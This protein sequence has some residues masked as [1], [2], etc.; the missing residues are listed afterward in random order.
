MTRV[1]HIVVVCMCVVLL[2]TFNKDVECVAHH[3]YVD[4]VL[5]LIVFIIRLVWAKH[6]LVDECIVFLLLQVLE[7]VSDIGFAALNAI[8]KNHNKTMDYR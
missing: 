3:G 6:L 7:T 4:S 5:L 1:E 8:P 2:L